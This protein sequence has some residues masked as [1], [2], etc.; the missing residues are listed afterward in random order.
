MSEN[1][2][3]FCN[4][5]VQVMYLYYALAAFGPQ[6][7]KYLWWKKYIT[8]IQLLQFATCFVYG[9][10]MV[11]LQ[12]GFPPG[13][14]WIGFAQNPFFFYMFYDFYQKAYYNKKSS[15]SSSSSPSNHPQLTAN[16]KL[17]AEDFL[18][19]RKENGNAS[20]QQ[21]KKDA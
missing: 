3:N 4:L 13:L 5:F 21:T 18:A 14:F 19:K 6:I 10:I 17:A 11:F 16:G 2:T 8:Q 1:L 15:S 9:V 12:E 20:V 7:Q